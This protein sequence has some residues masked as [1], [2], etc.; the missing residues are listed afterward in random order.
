MGKK[1]TDDSEMKRRFSGLALDEVERLVNLRDCFE[2]QLLTNQKPCI[3]SFV[4]G[5]RPATR[6]PLLREL[7]MLELDHLLK[8]DAAPE[9]GVYVQRFP[10]DVASVQSAFALILPDNVAS[11]T[12][13]VS[14]NCP[15]I[16]I[17]NYTLLSE[18]GEGGMGTV[19]RA[20]HTMLKN[21][22]AIKVLRAGTQEKSELH[23]LFGRETRN[24]GQLRHPQ[25]VQALYAGTTDDGLPYLVMEMVKGL[26][27]S[28][29]VRRCGPLAVAD[30]CEIVRQASLGLQHAHECGMVHR[31]IKPSNLLLGWT[32]NEKAEIKV[33]DFG[34]VRLF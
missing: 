5:C 2:Q 32:Y 14:R 22:A 27:L 18:L 8:T 31:D 9:L 29:V 33:A 19:Y 1:Q 10:R 13:S 25:I 4:A 16:S 6:E 11:H 7:L 12:E 28:C 20:L 24:L 34:L 17:P 26:D 30:A 21:E 3:E 15:L 23:E